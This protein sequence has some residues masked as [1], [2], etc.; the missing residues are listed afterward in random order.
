MPLSDANALY[1]KL[2]ETGEL[3]DLYVQEIPYVETM[4]RGAEGVSIGLDNVRFA[5]IAGTAGR[6]RGGTESSTIP[7]YSG[8]TG[9]SL[10]EPEYLKIEL[11]TVQGEGALALTMNEFK[12]AG[13]DR[14]MFSTVKNKIKSHYQAFTSHEHVTQ[15][16]GAS[17]IFAKCG[18]AGS[19]AAVTKTGFATN[20]LWS[21]PISQ[22]VDASSYRNS[23]NANIIRKGM[24]VEFVDTTNQEVIDDGGSPALPYIGT[25]N[26]ISAD[27]TTMLVAWRQAMANTATDLNATP[28]IRV[29]SPGLG[30]ASGVLNK[31]GI[32][33]IVNDVNADFVDNAGN[34]TN[35]FPYGTTESGIDPDTNPEWQSIVLGMLGPQTSVNDFDRLFKATQARGFND[36][37]KMTR[38]MLASPDVQLDLLEEAREYKRYSPMDRNDQTQAGRDVYDDKALLYIDYALPLRTVYFVDSTKLCVDKWDKE[39]LWFMP[40]FT[41]EGNGVK[42]IDNIFGRTPGS[43]EYQANSAYFGQRMCAERRQHARMHATS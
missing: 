34:N 27:G 8:T 35:K 10:T 21:I 26:S 12:Y 7:G 17:G 9:D 42:E 30:S 2:Y 23:A 38:V 11:A 40:P 22:V 24:V 4:W 25:V 28:Y 36:P 20:Q 29:E 6:L 41:S 16:F 33:D 31:Y 19:M 15:I 32:N 39:G 5:I 1:K 43:K 13:T 3:Y 14:E 37:S 18:A